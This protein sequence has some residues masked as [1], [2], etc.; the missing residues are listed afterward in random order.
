VEANLT[1]RRYLLMFLG[2][3]AVAE[4]PRDRE[5]RL[6]ALVDMDLDVGDP[7]HAEGCIS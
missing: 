3:Q 2:N 7:A 6:I 1:G 5:T 4:L